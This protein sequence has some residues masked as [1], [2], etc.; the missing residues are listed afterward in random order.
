MNLK[1]L[2]KIGLVIIV[3]LVV[4]FFFQN[5]AGLVWMIAAVM[6]G[7]MVRMWMSS[8]EEPI[9]IPV[10]DRLQQFAESNMPMELRGIPLFLAS[11]GKLGTLTGYA[12]TKY[13]G[14]DYTIASVARSSG[15]SKNVQNLIFPSELLKRK[16]GAWLIDATAVEPISQKTFT[17]NTSELREAIELYQSKY[18]KELA[19]FILGKSGNMVAEAMQANMAVKIM[20]AMEKKTVRIPTGARIGMLP[21]AS[22]REGQMPQAPTGREGRQ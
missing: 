6:I 12:E 4:L 21:E 5:F 14:K 8:R 9:E 18:D 22:A 16:F 11:G 1:G 3:G 20:N 2:V 13:D 17:V 7:Y 10:D 15:F 19:M